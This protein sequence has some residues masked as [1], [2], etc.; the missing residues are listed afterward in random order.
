MDFYQ[1]SPPENSAN[2]IRVYSTESLYDVK[3]KLNMDV[4]IISSGQLKCI[5]LFISKYSDSPN[6]FTLT[7]F[8]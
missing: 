4:F 3:I 1:A 7:L 8:A 2:E 5:Q 6:W